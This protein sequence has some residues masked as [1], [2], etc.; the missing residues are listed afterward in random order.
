M[1]NKNANLRRIILVTAVFLFLLPI[2]CD[3]G[4][5]VP[6]DEN[7][8]GVLYVQHGGMKYYKPQYMWDAV[9]HQFSYDNNHS[10]YN[11]V[12]W[13]PFFWSMILDRET[14]DFAKRFLIMYE[15][16]YERM[17]GSDPY[18]DISVKQ[19][20][21]LTSEL[22]NNTYGYEFEVDW[23]GYMGAEE[24]DHYPYP[25]YL[26]TVPNLLTGIP[27]LIGLAGCTYC[28]ENE[29][30]GPWEDCDP[31]RYN[32][33]GPVERLLKKGVSSIVMVDTTTGGVRFSKT[34]D[35][36][37]MTKRALEDWNEAHGTSIPLVW[38][39]D[40]NNV[41]EQSYPSAP[42]NWTNSKKTPDVDRHF[43][44]EGNNNPVIEDPVL[45]QLHVE[46][47]EASFSTSVPDNATAVVLFNHA[48]HDYNE[49]FDPKIDDTLILN[50]N[51]KALL[52]Q[53][54]PD[55]D[56]DNI[57]GAYGGIKEV[58]PENGLEERVRD[59]RGETYGYAWL[60][61]SDKQLPGDEW[62]YRYW[63]AFSYLKDRGVQHIVIGFPQHIA[64]NNLNLIEVPNQFG[65]EIG[66]K[67][68]AHYD[69]G[70]FS[71]YPEV[72]HPFYE[73]WGNWVD[74]DCGGEEC[75]FEMGGCSD[76]R[77]Y[78]PPRQTPLDKK[79]ADLDPSLAFDMSDYGHLGYDP[80]LGPP[81]PNG[82][83]QEQ[84]TGTWD[85]YRPPNE[86]PRLGKM[87]AKHVL[88]TILEKLQ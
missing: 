51:I 7:K 80:T 24:V 21:D 29:P 84:Y 37:Q 70:D 75:C 3:K 76:G 5:D 64:D 60:Y 61:E 46:S 6:I 34:F 77:V 11:F 14:T 79:R 58:N 32:V 4:D 25:R 87:L 31:E 38:V 88:N 39:N 78:P 62:G 73:Y 15:F 54:H 10:I 67:T 57:I 28:G 68:W 43:S 1:N 69:T 74:T 23:V 72:G 42:V 50:K 41:M 47:L 52:L 27:P 82:P 56:P 36:I 85:M 2:A 53:R 17:G 45:A 40:P 81:D 66:I 55:M 86:D 13:N 26:Y 71:L 44:L 65:K 16:G 35:V 83:V 30:D 19:L 12:I 49:F 9:V 59:M 8:I 22:D 20:D 18:P 48:L 63:E 33:D